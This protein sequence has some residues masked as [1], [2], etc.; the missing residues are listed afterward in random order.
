MSAAQRF[1]LEDAADRPALYRVSINTNSG[2][3]N[4]D[5][6]ACD[7]YDAERKVKTEFRR[8]GEVVWSVSAR[9]IRLAQV[10]P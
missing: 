5:V 9:M 7:A 1:A 4:V 3:H 6:K 8:R 2:W 10:T